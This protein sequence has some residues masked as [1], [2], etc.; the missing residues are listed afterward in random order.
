MDDPN[1]DAYMDSLIELLPC[2][3]CGSTE[4]VLDNLVDDYDYS[5]SC[6][7]CE[8]QQLANYPKDIAVARWNTRAP[9]STSPRQFAAKELSRLLD[10]WHIE[11]RRGNIESSDLEAWLRCHAELEDGQ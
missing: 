6:G 8:V 11:R 3:F 2:P 5:V 1:K 7:E 9:E 10:T 4:L